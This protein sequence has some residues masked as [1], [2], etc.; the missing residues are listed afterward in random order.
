M[1]QPSL[2]TRRF[3]EKREA[4]LDA[5]A[6]L[7]NEVGVKG[8]TLA[9]IARSVGLVTTSVTYYYRRKELLAAACFMRTVDAFSEL[10]VQ[11]ARPPH[12]N[13]RV[14]SYFRLHADR[15][16]AEARGERPQLVQ[17]NDL[18]AL[19]EPQFEETSLA[20]TQMFRQVRKLLEGPETS[21]LS[22]A[23]LN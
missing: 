9:D 2:K 23:E 20:Y 14:R 12:I 6:R 22:R 21:S 5:A 19:P 1:A 18:R 15:L 13:E 7:F 3:K 16:A 11:A 17:L 10:A 4:I 8:A